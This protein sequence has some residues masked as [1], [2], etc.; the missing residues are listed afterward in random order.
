MSRNHADLSMVS[1]QP[2]VRDNCMLVKLILGMLAHG[3]T[4]ETIL[5]EFPSIDEEDVR[6]V[7]AA[8]REELTPGPLR[9][10]GR[11]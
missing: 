1:G 3:E 5:R 10:A 6:A 9:S 2:V 7:I 11:A 8:K 4:T